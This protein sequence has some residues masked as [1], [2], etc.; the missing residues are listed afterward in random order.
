VR[1]GTLFVVPFD[2]ETLSMKGGEVRAAENVWFNRDGTADYAVSDD[3]LLVYFATSSDKMITTLKWID[4]SGAMKVL[5]G[6]ATERWGNGRL[7]PDGKFVANGIWDS[8]NNQDLWTYEVTTGRTNRL[9]FGGE[10]SDPIWSNDSKSILYSAKTPDGRFGIYS[11]PSDAS[12]K[13][14]LLATTQSSNSVRSMTADRRLVVFAMTLETKLPALYVL[15]LDANGKAGDPKQLNDGM[16]IERDGQISPDGQWIAYTSTPIN[17]NFAIDLQRFP[18]AGARYR[19]SSEGSSALMPR[20]SRSPNSREL[21][22]WLDGPWRLMATTISDAGL[23]SEPKELLK[24]AGEVE[25]TF[26]VTPDPNKFLIELPPPYWPKARLT[27]VTNW[28][29]ELADLAKP[30]K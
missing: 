12:A 4:R 27:I 2:L 20:W 24:M 29:Q 15:P 5:P 26:D 9:T 3:G 6:Q 30:K 23:P 1:D 8:S 13:G 16:E 21:V 25:S 17:G 10:N 19:I 18:V 22:F 11:V 28:F 7:S 14:T